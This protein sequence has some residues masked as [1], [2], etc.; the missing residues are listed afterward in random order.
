MTPD[1][2]LRALLEKIAATVGEPPEH[3]LDGIAA[4]RRR[5]TRRRRGAVATAV[6]L[7][8]LGVA[9]SPR[10]AWLDGDNHDIAASDNRSVPRPAQLPDIVDLRCGEAGI[11]VPVT[12]IQP[13]PDGLHIAVE[14]GFSQPIE[15]WVTANGW[16]SGRL[17]APP[18]ISELRQAVPPG[19]LTVGCQIG[20][21]DQQ[22]TVRLVDVRTTYTP[23]VLSCRPGEHVEIWDEVLPVQQTPSQLTATRDAMRARDKLIE[24]DEIVPYGG[25]PEQKAFGDPSLDP[26]T[27]IKRGNQ[28]V[29]LVHLSR[30]S[31]VVELDKSQYWMAVQKVEACT[32]FLNPPDSSTGS[33]TTP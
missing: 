28:T 25:Y 18:G 1:D 14:N 19:Q 12:S 32:G 10:L 24:G 29:A 16:D 31:D 15:V 2:Q 33:T 23:P 11:D 6:A 4:R 27:M 22:R 17:L 13:Q 26:M 7:A 21:E 20:V 8:V 30:K 3:G 5:R 9:A